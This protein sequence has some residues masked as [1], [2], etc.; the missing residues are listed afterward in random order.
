M[1]INFERH[2][3]ER[4]ERYLAE[5]NTQKYSRAFKSKTDL[6]SISCQ[7]I[8]IFSFAVPSRKKTFTI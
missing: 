3:R 5:S 6:V 7:F 4:L 8:F 1:K 2:I